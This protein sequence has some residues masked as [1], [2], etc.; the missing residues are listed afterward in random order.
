MREDS[1]REGRAEQKPN[2]KTEGMLWWENRRAEFC[3][4]RE[5]AVE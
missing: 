4:V 1:R 5:E 2:G 3:V